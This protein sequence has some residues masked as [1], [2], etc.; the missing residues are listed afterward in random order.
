MSPRVPEGRSSQRH[1][2]K[3]PLSLRAWGAAGPGQRAESVDLSARGVLMETDA[4]LDIGAFVEVRLRFPEE[5]TGQPSMEWRCKG[6]VVRTAC[7]DLPK[8][9]PRVG[10][11][12]DWLGV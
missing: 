1:T 2:L 10:L 3:I 4:D 5:I 12:F 6:R 11:H 9:R 7:R 8:G